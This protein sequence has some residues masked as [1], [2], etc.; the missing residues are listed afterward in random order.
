MEPVIALNG[1]L[2]TLQK[3]RHINGLPAVSVLVVLIILIVLIIDIVLVYFTGT[4]GALDAVKRRLGNLQAA[5]RS[6]V[7]AAVHGSARRDVRVIAGILHRHL[8]AGDGKCAVPP[9]DP[10]KPF[11]GQHK[12]PA[13]DFLLRTVADGKFDAVHIDA[14]V[15]PGVSGFI[16]EKDALYGCRT[17]S[18]RRGVLRLFRRLRFLCR[19]RGRCIGGRLCRRVGRRKLRRD[20]DRIDFDHIFRRLGRRLLAA[21]IPAAFRGNQRDYQHHD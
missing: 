3:R 14:S 1:L 16:L 2:G 21:V 20:D 15:R 7:T 6:E 13:L 11:Y 8:I 5:G 10:V 18:R 9:A 12:R 19:L 4:D 17:G